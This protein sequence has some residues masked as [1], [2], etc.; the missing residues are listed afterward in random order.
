MARL[1]TAGFASVVLDS[2]PL[3]AKRE[4]VARGTLVAAADSVREVAREAEKAL[5]AAFAGAGL[6]KLSRSWQ[7]DAYPRTG[8]AR[9]PAAEIYPKGQART[10][11]AVAAYTR[12]AT[13]K[14]GSG[15]FLAI[16][17]PA[18]GQKM[19]GRSRVPLTPAEWERRTG[20]RLRFVYRRNRPSLLVLD[21]GVLSGKRQVAKLNTARRRATG[22]NNQTIPIFVLM[23]QVNV[24]A[25]VS[26]DNIMRP[27]A[28]RLKAEF[29]QRVAALKND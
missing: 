28:G 8:P 5:E 2:K 4:R 22:R 29:A 10:R 21:E 15:Q 18:A 14:G 24:R 19:T 7:S 20:L 25:R 12:G 3:L 27:F 16:P 13:I 1:Y 17:L 9:E 23:P 11:G 6:G 26:I